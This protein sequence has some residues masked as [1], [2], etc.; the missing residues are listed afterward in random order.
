MMREGLDFPAAVRRLAERAHIS[1]P[2][3]ID[4]RVGPNRDQRERLYEI[5][6]KVRD[7][8]HLNLLL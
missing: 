2:N 1:L 8:F 7:W 5:N 6:Q 4:F 3:E